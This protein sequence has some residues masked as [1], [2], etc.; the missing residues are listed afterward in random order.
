VLLSSSH[1][2]GGYGALSGSDFMH[3]VFFEIGYQSGFRLNQKFFV[4]WEENWKQNPS[5]I[6]V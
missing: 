2:K 1:E 3:P 4:C 5:S 6:F